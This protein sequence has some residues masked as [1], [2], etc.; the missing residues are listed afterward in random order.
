MTI[1]RNGTPN[2][3]SAWLCSRNAAIHNEIPPTI[4]ETVVLR[5]VAHGLNCVKCLKTPHFTIERGGGTLLCMVMRLIFRHMVEVRMQSV[6]TQN[7]RKPN[8]GQEGLHA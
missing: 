8:T 3:N 1:D 7:L 4:R 5:R 2:C 6:C